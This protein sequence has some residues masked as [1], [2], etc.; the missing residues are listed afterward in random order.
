MQFSYFWLIL[1]DYFEFFY[2]VNYLDKLIIFKVIY[3]SVYGITIIVLIIL[4]IRT[5][6]INTLDP[7]I[8]HAK[9]CKKLK[10]FFKK[11]FKFLFIKIYFLLSKEYDDSHL[12][13]FCS[14]CNYSIGN[15]SYHCEIC[16]KL[17]Y[18]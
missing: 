3:T 17:L 18:I 4:A 14:I 15:D 7:N 13:K 8:I 16:N 1:I 10:F 6:S 5:T 2:N 12:S 9:I 11:K